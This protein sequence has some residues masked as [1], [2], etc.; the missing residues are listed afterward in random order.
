MAHIT[1]ALEAKCRQLMSLPAVDLESPCTFECQGCG[2]HC[3]SDRDDLL[4]TPYSAVR[5]A[6][7]LQDV[8][9]DYPE[10]KQPVYRPGASAMAMGQGASSHLPLAMLDFK[11]AGGH[12]Y[13]PFLVAADDVEPSDGTPALVRALLAK[14]R[15]DQ[16]LAVCGIYPVRPNA[17]RLF[18]LGRI[19]EPGENDSIKWQYVLQDVRCGKR[20]QR[21]DGLTWGEWIDPQEQARSAKGLQ[22]YTTMV[23]TVYR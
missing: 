23:Q 5:I 12:T 6:W 16:P 19:G 20:G 2:W 10:W 15:T 22:V 8:A 1:T 13:C 3:C 4:L 9:A 14:D 11:P 7:W 18:P 21:A 17:C